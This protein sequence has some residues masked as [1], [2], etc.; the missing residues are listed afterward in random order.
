LIFATQSVLGVIF[1][2]GPIIVNVVLVV[3][4]IFLPVF[5]PFEETLAKHIR[6][7]L[8][9]L[10]VGYAIGFFAITITQSLIN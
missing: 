9:T 6:L 5:K 3:L 4:L 10:A 8:I 2:Y 1:M 7:A